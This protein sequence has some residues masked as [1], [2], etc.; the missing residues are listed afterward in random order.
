M[1]IKLKI[2]PLSYN[3]YYKNSRT[4]RRIKT[5]A[6]LAYDEELGELLAEHAKALSNFGRD[7]DLSKSI[8]KLEIFNFKSRFFTKSGELSKTSG[9]WDNP[10][11]VLQDKVFKLMGIDDYVIK[12]GQVTDMPSNE[13]GVMLR[14]TTQ[15]M[16]RLAS[17]E[18]F[19]IG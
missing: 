10:I 1:I 14:I 17:L 15:E 6:G 3:A 9:D 5:G 16:P 18:D 11:K 4:G 8:V 2:K 19:T 12:I 13:D 7:L